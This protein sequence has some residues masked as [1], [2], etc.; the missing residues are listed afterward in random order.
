MN[1]VIVKVAVVIAAVSGLVHGSPLTRT[2]TTD[3]VL[4]TV[5]PNRTI[6]WGDR[7]KVS[8]RIVA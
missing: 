5:Y 8:R 3:S 2:G 4:Y 7:K 1:R 6:T